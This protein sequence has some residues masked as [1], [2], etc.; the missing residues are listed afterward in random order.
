MRGKRSE[1]SAFPQRTDRENPHLVVS[2]KVTLPQRP[3]LTGVG[4][5]DIAAAGEPR[6]L[7]RPAYID[8][9]FKLRPRMPCIVKIGDVIELPVFSGWDEAYF[10]RMPATRFR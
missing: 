2:H 3:E 9:F 7:L 1:Y 10:D 8:I 4:M 6:V 5:R